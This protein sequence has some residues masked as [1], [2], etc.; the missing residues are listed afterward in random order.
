MIKSVA[1]LCDRSPIGK[2]SVREALR[3]GAGFMGLGEEIICKVILMGD[4]VHLLSKT[5]KPTS[6]GVDSY[7]EPIEMA[8]LSDLEIIVLQESLDELGFTIDDLI[9]YEGL[10]VVNMVQLIDILDTTDTY[11]KY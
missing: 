9:E 7:D 4:A 6:V 5:A 8:E 1:I 3:L 11:F 2:N 10:K